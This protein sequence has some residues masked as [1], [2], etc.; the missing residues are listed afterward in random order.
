M[1]KGL[2]SFVAADCETTGL[3]P[4]SDRIVEV[5]LV[6][7]RDG[8]PVESFSTY[9]NPERDI[10]PEV[11]AVHGITSR[12]IQD[13]PCWPE[14]SSHVASFVG[15]RELVVAHHADFD[16]SFLRCLDSRAW[17][18]SERFARHLW[19]DA[20]SYKNQ[21]LRYYLGLTPNDTREQNLAHRA[22]DD[23]RITGLLF[24]RGLRECAVKGLPSDGRSIVRFVDS[25]VPVKVFRYGRKH[26]GAWIDEIPLDYLLWVLL[27]SRKSEGERFMGVDS[28][29]LAA[30]TA[31]LLVRSGAV[32]A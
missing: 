26:R 31:S 11:S 17:A 8:E 6:R 4:Q 12:D 3:D 32:A 16:R 14:V 9:V 15:P 28:D 19:H 23:A 22:L 25:P 24:A 7:F 1:T 29:T 21:V 18:C 10:P 27:D 2:T 13:A 5:A 20:P 30:V